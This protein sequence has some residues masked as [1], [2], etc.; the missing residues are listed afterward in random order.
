MFKLCYLGSNIRNSK[1]GKVSRKM[2]GYPNPEKVSENI[3]GYSKSDGYQSSHIHP[4][5]TI[6]IRNPNIMQ[7]SEKIIQPDNLMLVC[8]CVIRRFCKDPNA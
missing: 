2:F 8:V 6:R 4:N 7:I 1:S 5:S 3:S